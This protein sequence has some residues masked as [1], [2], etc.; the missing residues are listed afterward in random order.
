MT[1]KELEE[2]INNCILFILDKVDPVYYDEV[3]KSLKNFIKILLNL[4]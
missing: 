2:Y 3:K 4:R 1:K